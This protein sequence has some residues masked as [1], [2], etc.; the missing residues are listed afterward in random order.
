MSFSGS[1]AAVWIMRA[2]V[3][4]FFA[5]AARVSAAGGVVGDF[6]R[7]GFLGAVF[8]AILFASRCWWVCC[9]RYGERR[10]NRIIAVGRKLQFD[11]TSLGGHVGGKHDDDGLRT[12]RHNR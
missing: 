2:F 4:I 11:V 7:A 10:E 8:L 12:F 3:L 6:L 9:R 1:L 5:N